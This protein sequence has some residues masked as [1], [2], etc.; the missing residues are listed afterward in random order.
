MPPPA[1]A[2]V[3]INERLPYDVFM[4]VMMMMMM[5]VMVMVNGEWGLVNGDWGLVD[6]QKTVSSYS[7]QFVNL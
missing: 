2:V 3:L 7:S 1:R 4:S 6:V 5:M